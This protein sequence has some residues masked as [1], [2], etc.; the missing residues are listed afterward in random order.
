M[1]VLYRE[2]RTGLPWELY[3]D[4]IVL[5]AESLEEL[6]LLV[7]NWKHGIEEKG[8]HDNAGKTKVMMSR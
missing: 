1:E 8:I 3:A 5:M 7:E 2:L 6:V 4:D